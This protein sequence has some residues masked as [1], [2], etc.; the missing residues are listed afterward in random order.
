MAREIR[1][2]EVR[3][4]EVSRWPGVLYL[5]PMPRAPFAALIERVAARFPEHPPYAGAIDEV[6]PH[7]TIAEEIADPSRL[8]LLT[9]TVRPHLPFRAPAVGL[10]VIAH[11]GDERWRRRWRL[12]FG[13]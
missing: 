4:G 10:D 7:L 9:A 5:E 2:F 13:A 1:A 8:D 3:F 6:I 12:P 11:D